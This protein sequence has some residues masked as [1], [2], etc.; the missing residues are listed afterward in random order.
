MKS[1]WVVKFKDGSMKFY[2]DQQYRK[3]CRPLKE[4]EQV[5]LIEQWFDVQKCKDFYRK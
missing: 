5:L 4:Q 1:Y 3:Y 2:N